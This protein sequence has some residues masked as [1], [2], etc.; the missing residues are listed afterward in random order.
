MPK[1]TAPKSSADFCSCARSA[2]AFSS[3]C[4]AVPCLV[5]LY[6]L[7][8]LKAL[9]LPGFR[10]QLFLLQLKMCSLRSSSGNWDG[11]SPFNCRSSDI[12]PLQALHFARLPDGGKSGSSHVCKHHDQ[13]RCRVNRRGL[14]PTGTPPRWLIASSVASLEA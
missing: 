12:N 7:T 3:F 8:S 4:L 2:T 5:N 13:Q 1:S 11:R 9:I 10:L 14:F 6:L